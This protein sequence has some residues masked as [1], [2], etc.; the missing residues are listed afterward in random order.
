[1]TNVQWIPTHRVGSSTKA[2]NCLL[3]LR[4]IGNGSIIV[5]GTTQSLISRD[6]GVTWKPY[7]HIAR[8]A[9]VHDATT[10]A[11][12]DFVFARCDQ[13]TCVWRAPSARED[14]LQLSRLPGAIWLSSGFLDDGSLVAGLSRDQ[15]VQIFGSSDRGSTWDQVITIR[16][17]G[18]SAHFAIDPS[19]IALCI[20]L[21]DAEMAD[22]ADFRSI[23]V[24]LDLHQKRILHSQSVRANIQSVCPCGNGVWLLG[25]NGGLIFR[26][27]VGDPQPET[28]AV[29]DDEDLNI[30]GIHIRGRDGIIVAEESHP[31]G[32]I[33]VFTAQERIIGPGVE[34]RI[35]GFSY[36]SA[37]VEDA[38]VITT[39]H[40][41]FRG[42]LV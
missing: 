22:G 34:T 32:A 12:E 31:P 20:F 7:F 4:E 17:Y 18:P 36:G 25:A 19:G 40:V 21:E 41:V 30:T 6:R 2:D 1:M 29:L 16:E 13:E 33:K 42:N 26:F 35:R 15:S 24:V 5:F 38:V 3:G 10:N 11:G 27:R 28:Y 14:W 37:W 9:M 8:D 23:L 39:P